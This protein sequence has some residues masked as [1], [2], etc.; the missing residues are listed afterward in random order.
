MLEKKAL[1]VIMIDVRKITTLTDYFVTCTSESEPQTRAIT[2]HI[3]E[4]MKEDGMKAWHIVG[5][6]Y[7]DW[8]LLDYVNIVVHVFSRDSRSYYDLERLWADGNITP[9]KD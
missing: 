2:D 7:L 1:D 3:H 6:E 4:N 8:V 5:Y 9:I